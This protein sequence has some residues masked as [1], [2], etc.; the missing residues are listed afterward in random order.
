MELEEL[1]HG[2]LGN[3]IGIIE[4]EFTFRVILKFWKKESKNAEVA[5]LTTQCATSE[6]FIQSIREKF[7]IKRFHCLEEIWVM[8]VKSD[9][10]KPLKWVKECGGRLKINISDS[11][12]EHLMRRSQQVGNRD[13]EDPLYD[14]DE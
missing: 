13:F 7:E 12:K 9:Y 10:Q 5:F 4:E 2:V 3:E 1:I 11:F 14:L 6:V 8:Q